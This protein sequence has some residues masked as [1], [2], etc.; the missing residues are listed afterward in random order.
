MIFHFGKILNLIKRRISREFYEFVLFHF[1]KILNLIQL[2][3]LREFA[4]HVYF[5]F[6]NFWTW[7]TWESENLKWVLRTSIFSFDKFHIQFRWEYYPRISSEF[8]KLVFLPLITPY[9]IQLR[10]HQRIS[11][12]FEEHIFFTFVNISTWFT[13]ESK[14]L[15]LVWR[16]SIFSFDKFYIQFRWEYTWESKVNLTNLYFYFREISY[17]IQMRIHLKISRNV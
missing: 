6:V 3:I 16:T 17:T 14:N 2:R 10:I 9:T 1:C 8:H 13:W 15:K 5:T 4:E 7:F 11:R 12:E